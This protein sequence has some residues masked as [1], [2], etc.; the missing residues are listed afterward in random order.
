MASAL[1]WRL[2]LPSIVR[3]PDGSLWFPDGMVPYPTYG[4]NFAKARKARVGWWIDPSD[5]FITMDSSD[6]ELVD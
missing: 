2:S 5:R 3:T 1:N 4:Y 6:F